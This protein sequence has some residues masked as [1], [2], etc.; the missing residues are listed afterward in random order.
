L[1]VVGPQFEDFVEGYRVA[2]V[3]EKYIVLYRQ[4][5]SKERDSEKRH[6]P[7]QA[8]GLMQRRDQDLELWGIG[9]FHV[10]VSVGSMKRN[11]W[12]EIDYSPIPCRQR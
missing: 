11:G 2:E 12:W 7:S 4:A 3:A 5:D 9:L 10:K 6:S 8:E 1:R